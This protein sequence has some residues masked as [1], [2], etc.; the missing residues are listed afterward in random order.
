MRRDSKLCL[1]PRPVSLSSTGNASDQPCFP[2]LPLPRVAPQKIEVT[3]DNSRLFLLSLFS[4][5]PHTKPVNHWHR[6]PATVTPAS[7]LERS[8]LEWAVGVPAS[9]PT[10][11]PSNGERYLERRRR[12]R[13]RRRSRPLPTL[14]PPSPLFL[15]GSESSLPPPTGK[16]ASITHS[17]HLFRRQMSSTEWQLFS[18][19]EKML[20]PNLTRN[21]EKVSKQF[22][23]AQITSFTVLEFPVIF[24]ELSRD[25]LDRFLLT[26]SK[27][28]SN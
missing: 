15:P 17:R 25:I 3:P 14:P 16:P 21:H 18:I 8:P 2:P 22:S 7:S 13:E 9:R 5:H 20:I 11:L 24:S 1:S 26:L 4:L 28:A 23:F 19:S 27:I 6:S 10:G 12:G